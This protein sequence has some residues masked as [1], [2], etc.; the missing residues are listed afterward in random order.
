[1]LFRRFFLWNR[2]DKPFGI[3]GFVIDA[4]EFGSL[5]GR[6]RGGIV[7]EKGRIAETGD[8]DDLR[9]IHSSKGSNGSTTGRSRFFPG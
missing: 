3:R 2:S 8:Y 1:M 5:R 6:R 9:R 4:P 7:V